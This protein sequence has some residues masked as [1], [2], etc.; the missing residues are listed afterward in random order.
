MI[1]TITDKLLSNRGYVGSF[2]L[3]A[4][5]TSI[6]F[7]TTT[8]GATFLHDRFAQMTQRQLLE[9]TAYYAFASYVSLGII[10][11]VFLLLLSAELMPETGQE[12]E[13]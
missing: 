3:G 1:R 11:T 7:F 8:G 5:L 4:G 10:A 9:N 2:G 12:A 6:V 13:Q